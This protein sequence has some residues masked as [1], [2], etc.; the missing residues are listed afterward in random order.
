MRGCLTEGIKTLSMATFGRIISL[1]ELRL[2]PYLQF[3]LMNDKVI[4]YSKID[5]DEREILASWQSE[6]WFFY[7]NDNQKIMVT[8][9]FWD[10]MNKILFY[11]YVYHEENEK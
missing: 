6:G 4:D 8:K 9:E 2:M 3:V 7:Y 11:S 10:N 1:K 5:M